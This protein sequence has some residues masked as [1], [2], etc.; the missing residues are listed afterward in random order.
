M[1]TYRNAPTFL[2]IWLSSVRPE[3]AEGILTI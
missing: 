2:N 1:N 3:L